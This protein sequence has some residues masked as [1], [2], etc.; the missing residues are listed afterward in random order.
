MLCMLMSMCICEHKGVGFKSNPIQHDVW[1]K[2]C[3]MGQPV[4]CYAF[5]SC[6]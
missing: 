2:N 6:L 3:D 1:V 4:A 5:A